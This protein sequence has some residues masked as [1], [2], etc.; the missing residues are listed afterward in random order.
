MKIISRLKLMFN[1]FKKNPITKDNITKAMFKYIYYN[2]LLRVKNEIIY[3]GIEKLKFIIS[4]GDSGLIGNVY[5]GIYEVNESM[6]TVHFLR[7][8]DT[9]LDIGANLGHYSLIASGISKAR[10][11]AIEPI[12][13]TFVKL[14]KQ[15]NINNLNQLVF[16]FNIGLSNEVSN[17]F[18]S[19]D[20]QDMNHIVNS[21]YPN[22]IQIPVSTI[23][24]ISLNETI[25][26]IKMDVEGYEKFVLNGASKTLQNTNL[27]AIIIELNNSGKKYGILDEEVYQLIVNYG[28]LP[29]KYNPVEKELI[30]LESYNT[31][32]FNT[33]FIRDLPFVKNRISSS[34]K[35]KIW[36]KEV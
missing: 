26:L 34:K 33:I 13:S 1:R 24:L 25:A 6:F 30:Q 14:E 29:Y 2:I 32:Q 5:F 12:P 10:S 35:I 20:N 28:F 19:S 9:F 18:F 16:P 21:N 8:E 4:K 22:A 23:D 27:K 11:I 36:N 15:I 3:E 17:L 31:T 7:S